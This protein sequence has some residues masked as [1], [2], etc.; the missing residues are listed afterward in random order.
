M[1]VDRLFRAAALIAAVWFLGG[2][3][4]A[5]A[6]PDGQTPLADMQTNADRMV[7]V[8]VANEL[9]SVASKAGSTFR[10]YDS[11][12]PYQASAAAQST[13]AGLAKDYH[14]QAVASWPISALQAHCVVFDVG[15]Q[16]SRAEVMARLS[17]DKRVKL[18]QPLQSFGTRSSASAYNDPYVGLQTGF[19]ELDAADAHQYSRGAGIRVAVIDTG[20]D[21]A[22]PDLQG[23]VVVSRNFVDDDAHQFVRDKHG[24]EVAGVIA[25]VANNKQGIVGIAPEVKIIALKACWAD[26]PDSELASCNSFTLA[27][28][29]AAAIE[30]RARIVNLSLGGPDDQLL[31]ELVRAGQRRGMIFVGAAPNGGHM[32]GFPTGVAGVIAVGVARSAAPDA[33]A[34]MLIAPGHEILTLTPG[35]HYDFASGSSIAAAHV[36]GTVALLLAEDEKLDADALRAV[37]T[38]S[39]QSP[40]DGDG[41]IINACRALT[42]ILKQADCR[43]QV[44]AGEQEGS[45]KQTGIALRTG[46]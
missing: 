24:T 19:N 2:C 21:V 37:L 7:V 31:D 17:H 6:R 35:G 9:Q 23:R 4:G 26:T 27:K 5:G 33:G 43:S 38:E 13:V 20:M 46:P 22:H 15:S 3:A 39:R 29:I 44:P 28:A 40:A 42:R 8:T 12:T 11:W 41:S 45:P 16:A 18:V 25:A 34:N 32:N 10:S 14:M 30:Q 1:S 36:T